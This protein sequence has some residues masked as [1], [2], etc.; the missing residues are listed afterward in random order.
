M[1]DNKNKKLDFE[2]FKKGVTEYGLNY[3]KDEVREL[4]NMFDKDKSGQIDFEEFLEQLRV[5]RKPTHFSD[6]FQDQESNVLLCF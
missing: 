1:D 6:I 2:E 3:T 5:S 4:F